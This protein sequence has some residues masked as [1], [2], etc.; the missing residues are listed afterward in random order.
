MK[1][2]ATLRIA[3]CLIMARTFGHYLFSHGGPE[4]PTIAVYH[5]HGRTWWVPVED[6]R[7]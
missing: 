6:V 1:F 4:Q 2:L 3:Y 7:P 5:W